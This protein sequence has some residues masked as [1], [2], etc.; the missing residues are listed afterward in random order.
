[1]IAAQDMATCEALTRGEGLGTMTKLGLGHH[2]PSAIQPVWVSFSC[3]ERVCRSLHRP[4]LL[5]V[6]RCPSS[7]NVLRTR[8]RSVYPQRAALTAPPTM[9][10]LILQLLRRKF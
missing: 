10:P 1:M 2:P 4:L 5:Q 9:P 3:L 8:L 7:H 6:A